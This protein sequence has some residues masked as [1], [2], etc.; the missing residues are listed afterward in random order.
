MNIMKKAAL[1]TAT[2]ASLTGSAL[3]IAQPAQAADLNCNSGSYNK[4]LVTAGACA[5][6]NTRLEEA[7][8][9]NVILDINLAVVDTKQDGVAAIAYYRTAS[10]A[11]GSWV[12][13]R[14]IRLGRASGYNTSAAAQKQ[15]I[16]FNG[17]SGKVELQVC[18]DTIVCSP[19]TL[20][21]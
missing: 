3:A 19:W 9:L 7:S 21:Y 11:S 17:G 13:S 5:W 8:G 2:F 16:V 10:R 1:F 18:A 4:R 6:G 12:Y 20:A 14:S 15:D